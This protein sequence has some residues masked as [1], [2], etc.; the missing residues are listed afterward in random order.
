M[1]KKNKRWLIFLVS[2]LIIVT[3]TTTIMLN[4]LDCSKGLCDGPGYGILIIEINLLL[5][6]LFLVVYWIV[7]WRIKR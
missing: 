4:K 6:I 5:L 2:C 1:K 7:S 3:L